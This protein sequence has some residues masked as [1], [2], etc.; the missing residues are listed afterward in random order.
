MNFIKFFYIT[1]QRD[2]HAELVSASHCE[3]FLVFL[4]GQILKRVQDDHQLCSVVFSYIEVQNKL[5][6]H[7]SLLTTQKRL[8]DVDMNSR[9][10]S[11]P[12]YFNVR[13]LVASVKLRLSE[14]R[15]MLAWAMPSVS[16]LDEVKDANRQLS[17]HVRVF[18]DAISFS[19][20]LFHGFKNPRLFAL[21]GFASFRRL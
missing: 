7:Y 1:A 16:N 13:I 12:R 6:A 14:S 11:S 21:T 2:G 3:P 9:G 18:A 8:K 17:P 19:C 15:A 20:Q 10:L 4:R 5:K